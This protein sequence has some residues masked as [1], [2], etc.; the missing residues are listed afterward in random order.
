MEISEGVVVCSKRVLMFR[1]DWLRSESFDP[2]SCFTPPIAV[3]V[4]IRQ[5]ELGGVFR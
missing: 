4:R 3:G 1:V 5:E 2:L